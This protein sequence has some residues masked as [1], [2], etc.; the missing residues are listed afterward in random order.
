[1]TAELPSSK[2][3]IVGKAHDC[4][5]A[6]LELKKLLQQ[7]RCPSPFALRCL[8]SA[9]E[10]LKTRC[11]VLQSELSMWASSSGSSDILPS[12]LQQIGFAK[13]YLEHIITQ[14]DTAMAKMSEAT[15][16]VDLVAAQLKA[17]SLS[18]MVDKVPD[19]EIGEK[20]LLSVMARVGK[21]INE[22]NKDTKKIYE[23]ATT[24]AKKMRR[25]H[26]YF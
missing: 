23:R 25:G 14:A 6:L 7:V 26:A 22:L 2:R 5:A 19:P 15:V 16:R 20:K 10:T 11:S 12:K 24:S 3:N 8:T 1:M 18:D 21:E 17:N 4:I 9:G 13:E